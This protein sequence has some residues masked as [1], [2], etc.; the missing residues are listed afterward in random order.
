M[1]GAGRGAGRELFAASEGAR[2]MDWWKQACDKLLERVAM[3]MFLLLIFVTL[4]QVIS[5]Y[6]FPVPI[7]FT[8]EVGRFLFIWI[9]FLGAAIV[10]NRDEHIRLD[11]FHGRVSRRTYDA[12]RM[13]VYALIVV[14]SVGILLTSPDLLRVALRQTA[15]VSRIS[16]GTVYTVVP[17]SAFLTMGYAL[18][19][20]IRTAKGLRGGR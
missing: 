1:V 11:L 12:L 9:S 10:M 2:I 3:A 8:E 16:M 6:V 15:A 20:L 13:V 18:I 14:F 19:H 7:S 17:L 5:R 4:F